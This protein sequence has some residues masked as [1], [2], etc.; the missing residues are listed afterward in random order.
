MRSPPRLDGV[1]GSRSSTLGENWSTTVAGVRASGDYIAELAAS[2]KHRYRPGSEA[3]QETFKRTMID[4]PPEKV[5]CIAPRKASGLSSNRQRER[6]TEWP[7]DRA[8]PGTPSLADLRQ[9]AAGHTLKAHARQR[10]SD[11]VNVGGA[12]PSEACQAA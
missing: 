5:S 2:G 10:I 6:P 9:A 1:T 8:A 4:G 12:M 7:P 3:P 11:G